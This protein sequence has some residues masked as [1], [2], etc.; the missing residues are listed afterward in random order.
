MVY[1]S[2]SFAEKTGCEITVTPPSNYE[3]GDTFSSSDVKV[4]IYYAK[5]V[6][7]S[8]IK[9]NSSQWRSIGCNHLKITESGEYDFWVRMKLQNGLLSDPTPKARLFITPSKPMLPI[10]EVSN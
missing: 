6:G 7:S 3:N 1:A 8:D 9:L 4:Y 5:K 10:V 2:V